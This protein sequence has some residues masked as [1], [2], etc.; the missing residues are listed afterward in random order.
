MVTLMTN[1]QETTI[2]AQTLESYTRTGD[3]GTTTLGDQRE[4]S[5]TDL[6]LQAFGDCEEANAAIGVV[7]AL[8]G[9]IPHDIMNLLARIQNDLF[10]VSTD[11]YAPISAEGDPEQ[12]RVNQAYVD[13]LERACDH[14]NQEL[15]QLRSFV[16]PGGTVAAALLH[17]AR[18][19]VRRA[20]RSTWQALAQH[21]E[22]MNPWTAT[23]LNRLSDLLFIIGRAANSEHGDT[24]WRSSRRYCARPR[25]RGTGH[26]GVG[27]WPL[28]PPV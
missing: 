15:P 6:R 7:L 17:R 24:L 13:Y 12:V 9:T 10:D 1:D 19:V 27:S 5:K 21:G 22:Q 4:V 28:R 3:N 20:E 11:L 23:Y 26:P 8:G 16:L 25:R 2:G 14:N 18:T